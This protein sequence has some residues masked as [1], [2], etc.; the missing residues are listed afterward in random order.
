VE[1]EVKMLADS[2][3]RLTDDFEPAV[4]ELLPLDEPA[5][6]RVFAAT[7]DK[8]KPVLIEEAKELYSGREAA[9]GADILRKV[10]RDIYL[11]IL[12][13]L[14]M[15]HLENMDHLREG[16]HWMSVGQRDPLVEY[17]RRGQLIFEE[18]QQALRHEVVR[19][20]FQS[21]PVA[22]E[23]LER[24]IETELTRAARNSISNAGS[25]VDADS[26]F[27]E[28]DFAGSKAAKAKSTSTKRKK[29]NKA[30]RQ[31]KTKARKRK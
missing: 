1:D 6:D 16:I 17:R 19:A 26:E 22:A 15:Q 14:W 8:V 28:S 31:R 2:P 23:D 12:D 20:L 13:N 7:A 5:L 18:M 11:Q 29:T 27:E 21:E 10:E 4:R 9:F 25:I 24:P 30:E 3:L